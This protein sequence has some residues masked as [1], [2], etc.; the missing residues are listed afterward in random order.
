[1]CDVHDYSPGINHGREEGGRGLRWRRGL[2]SV[3]RAALP[4]QRS[5]PRG[6]ELG[7]RCWLICPI[8]TEIS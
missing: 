1:M 4:A 7:F 5:L 2:R 6:S 8:P 3:F